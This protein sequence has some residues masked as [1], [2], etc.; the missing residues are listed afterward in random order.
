MAFAYLQSLGKLLHALRQGLQAETAGHGD[1][2]ADNAEI[3]A[4]RQHLTH[5]RHVDL[6][7]ACRKTL[8][9]GKRR[10]PRAK[11]VNCKG[12]T[13]IDQHCRDTP[14]RLGVGHHARL[15]DLKLDRAGR[16]ARLA[17]DHQRS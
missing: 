12:E 10:M 14:R 1:D 2:G 9:V 5:K 17:C 8:Q 13:G 6:Q 4:I 11:I 15:R 7:G 16:D 3:V